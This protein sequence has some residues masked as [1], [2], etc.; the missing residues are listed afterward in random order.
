MPLT[1]PAYS[2]LM[3]I[4]LAGIIVIVVVV[5]LYFL[6]K[7]LKAEREARIQEAQAMRVFL[8]EEREQNTAFLRE[9][10]EG[11]N[12][13]IG[14]LAEEIKSVRTE[15]AQLHGMLTAHDARSQEARKNRNQ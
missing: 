11:H 1:E 2:L 3:Q 10:A 13:V 5:F 14:R 7:W 6:D 12:Q 4:P 8:K 9:Q 15:M